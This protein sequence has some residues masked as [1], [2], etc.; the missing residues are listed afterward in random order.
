MRVLFYKFENNKTQTMKSLLFILTIILFNSCHKQEKKISATN[1][2]KDS[3][4]NVP[5]KLDL[6]VTQPK[7][8]NRKI[9]KNW[10]SLSAIQQNWIEVKKD[11]NGYLIYEPCD[12]YPRSISLKKGNLHIQ[13]Q[14]EPE[15]VFT[16]NKF[17]RVKQNKALMI[18]V[19]A[20]N[21]LDLSSVSAEIIDAENGLVLWEFNG[22]K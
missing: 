9:S 8:G 3:L 14:M 10:K 22:E 7:S 17:T 18:D 13:W 11:E 5:E 6:T 4:I 2:S 21:N 19:Y 12:G 15:V 20:G 16:I 1:S